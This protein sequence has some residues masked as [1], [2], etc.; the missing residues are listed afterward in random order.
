MTDKYKWDGIGAEGVQA[1]LAIADGDEDGV[2][3]GMNVTPWMA[4][5]FR[6][7]YTKLDAHGQATIASLCVIHAT[8]FVLWAAS[9][10]LADEGEKIVRH[11][12]Q[13]MA[14]FL[15]EE[16]DGDYDTQT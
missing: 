3:D 15:D 9:R 2:V 12:D 5:W 1:F 13:D 16:R 11:L 14:R 6:R 10:T 7:V 8:Q 4:R